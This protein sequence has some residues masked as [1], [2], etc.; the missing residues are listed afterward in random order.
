[1]SR[2]VFYPLKDVTLAGRCSPADV[3]LI[4]YLSGTNITLSGISDVWVYR[5][6]MAVR[7]GLAL[8]AEILFM[9]AAKEIEAT[10][11]IT[12]DADEVEAVCG[13]YTDATAEMILAALMT[14][15]ATTTVELQK[16]IALTGDINLAAATWINDM[17]TELFIGGNLSATDWKHISDLIAGIEMGAVLTNVEKPTTAQCL[18]CVLQLQ[19]AI[20]GQIEKHAIPECTAVALNGSIVAAVVRFRIVEDIVGLVVG[21]VTDWTMHDFYYLEV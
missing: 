15:V 20:V 3:T 16:A 13:K 14:T 2:R 21:D 11:G 5:D 12:L 8:V 1:M 17:S 19:G 7:S 9:N 18:E 6:Y 4:G 10:G